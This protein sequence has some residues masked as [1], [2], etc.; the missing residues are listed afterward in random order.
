VA[1]RYQHGRLWQLVPLRS[2]WPKR[3]TTRLGANPGDLHRR[4]RIRRGRRMR[5]IAISFGIRLSN[6]RWCAATP[7]RRRVHCASGTAYRC[8]RRDSCSERAG[9]TLLRSPAGNADN[10]AHDADE[11]CR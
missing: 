8:S 6:G 11:R 2:S 1:S 9:D 3:S 10:S 4:T 7:A 5:M